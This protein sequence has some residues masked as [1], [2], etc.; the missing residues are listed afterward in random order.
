MFAKVPEFL[1][2]GTRGFTRAE[3]RFL[4]FLMDVLP[5]KDREILSRQLQCVTKCK[6]NT[7]VACWSPT[8]KKGPRRRASP[9][10]KIRRQAG[11]QQRSIP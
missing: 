3:E 2:G 4:S 6:G 11:Q 8:M 5:T 10:F 9:L 1:L 7:P